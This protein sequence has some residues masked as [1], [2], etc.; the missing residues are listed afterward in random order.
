MQCSFAILA[1]LGLVW[2]AQCSAISSPEVRTTRYRRGL[3]SDP[4]DKYFH[5]SSFDAHYDGRFGTKKLSYAEKRRDLR[6]LALSYLSTMAEIGI[7]TWIMHG[8]LMGWWWNKKIM[9]WD[10]DLDVQMTEES[11]NFLANYY[12]MTVYHFATDDVPG[13][14][15]YMLEINP[16]YAVRDRK[17]HESKM[18]VIDARWIDVVSG[19]YVDITAVWKKSD[20]KAGEDILV[21]KDG[22]EYAE[23]YVFPLRETTF[24]GVPALIP[25]AYSEVLAAEYGE[26]SLINNDFKGYVEISLLLNDR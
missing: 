24:E 23:K 5:E 8:S 7:E 13:G 12:N 1:F 20:H 22:H 15:N 4:P 25:F 11:I 6:N 21:S 3:F 10:E 19:L 14:K 17:S 2:L 16:Y 18:N 26:A 9:P